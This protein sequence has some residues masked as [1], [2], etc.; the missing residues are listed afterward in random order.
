[1]KRFLARLGK[2]TSGSVGSVLSAVIV[3]G[4]VV[5]FSLSPVHDRLEY[6]LYD[7]RF[8][9]K[10]KAEPLPELVLLNVDD[11]SISA[12]GVYPW[13]RHYYAFAL[14]QLKTVGLAGLLFDFQ[15]MDS[16]PALLNPDGFNTL[17]TAISEGRR[18][19]ADELYT[20]I[21]DNDR[22]LALATQEF[23]GTVMPFS[24][25]KVESKLSLSPAAAE[26]KA[27]AIRRF[28]EKASLPIPTGKEPRFRTLSDADR[29]C[30]NYPIP[31]LMNAAE[32]FGF[33][34]ND[35]DADGAHRRVRLIRVFN[36]RIYLHLSL[37]AYL[38]MCGVGIGDIDIEP[39][40]SI[41]IRNAVHPISGMRGDIVIPV[42]R[43]CSI[44][45]DWMGDFAQTAR[46]V[47]AHA[48]IEYPFYAEQFEMQLML[49]DMASGKNERTEL[50]SKLEALKAAI[51]AEKDLEK[52]F[53]LRREY[54]KE[55]ERYKTV[56][57]GYLHES[58]AELDGLLA[59][60]EAGEAIDPESVAS[61]KTLITAI[62]IKTQVEYLFDSVAVLGLTAVGTQD[63][64]VTPLSSSYWMVGSY[65]TAINTLA[66]GRFIGKAPVYLEYIVMLA[67]AVALVLFIHKR[68]AKIAYGAIA[69]LVVLVNI[70]IMVLFSKAYIWIDQV[71][72]NLALILPSAIIMITKFAGEEEHRQF[73][74]GAFSKYLSQD[75][76]DQ[77]I[78]NPDAL[79]L[80]GESCTITTFFSDIAGFSG[81]SEKL[82]AQGLVQLLN[83]YLSEMTDIIM[84][85]RGTVD[86]Y[87]GDAIMAFWGAPLNFPEHPYQACLSAVE[88]QRRL[89]EMR[90]RWREQGRHELRVRM[91]INSGAAVAGNM[92][93]RV[94]M[95]YT[96]MGDSVNLA[97]RLEGANKVYGTYSMVSHN[98]HAAVKDQF[99]FRELDTIRVVGKSEPITVFEL[100]DIPGRV[101]ELKEVALG[102]Y[103]KGLALY[104][105]RRWKEALSGFA[106][107]L[108]IDI[109]DS[110]SKVYY[111]RCKKFLTTPPPPTWDGVSNLS[112][113]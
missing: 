19:K 82:S 97:S 75:V 54:R 109:E 112:S 17:H 22:D 36:D 60:K 101:P 10:P 72:F 27:A 20:M 43:S 96:V 55:L 46:H 62:K 85:N 23:P 3:C 78:A 95:N 44:Y 81:I 30:V 65:P 68:S 25:G 9:I 99:R 74:Q 12:L 18:I 26:T 63:E 35:A 33:V 42:D 90:I 100:L 31:E 94:R 15:F 48:L 28:T 16:S 50:S 39:G 34:D 104:K 51:L 84:G 1:M 102:H 71:S 8:A 59:R 57:Q 70:G 87:E 86:K 105:E 38:R 47:S 11:A 77:I 13:P 110:P 88:M 49:K 76:I 93:S 107:A 66:R 103:E 52:R 37:I 111:M 41:T 113:K 73:I 67:L 6:V 56:I 32:S 69:F 21:I 29:V 5:L 24:F 64:G 53:P 7:L 40:T 108:K 61:I 4:L 83:E 79:K 89:A 80:G 92:G 98:T 58:Q 2:L 106:H 91:G 45:F 14:R